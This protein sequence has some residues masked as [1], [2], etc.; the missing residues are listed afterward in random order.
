MA[1]TP[2]VIRT[3]GLEKRYQREGGDDTVAVRSL[4][5]D[6]RQGEVFGLLGPNGAGKTT[7]ILMLLG[8]TE[9]TGGTRAGARLRPAARP[10]AGQAARGLPAR[11]RRA[12][13][14]P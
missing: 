14:G 5:L 1:S 10:A 2:V 7:T 13:T 6:I 4:D 11:Q 9:P 8:L 12:S 3:R